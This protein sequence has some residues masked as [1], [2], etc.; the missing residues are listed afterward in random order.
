MTGQIARMRF[1]LDALQQ[2]CGQPDRPLS[3]CPTCRA[4][5][6]GARWYQEDDTVKVDTIPPEAQRL[7]AFIVLDGTNLEWIARCPDCGRLYWM[8]DEYEYS[9]NS[10]STTDRTVTRVDNAEALL[11]R[12]KGIRQYK[13]IVRDGNVWRAQKKGVWAA[14]RRDS[15]ADVL[16]RFATTEP[17]PLP[18][19]AEPPRAATV[20]IG[21]STIPDVLYDLANV[22]P[23]FEGV[24]LESQLQT[25]DGFLDIL[26]PT[27][28]AGICAL[29]RTAAQA[30]TISATRARLNAAA[31]AVERGDRAALP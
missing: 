25:Y 10:P 18:S 23:T 4:I 22:L 1:T 5:P 12:M 24:D 13:D 29:F 2:I 3:D 30:T 9:S 14:D 28:R 19:P 26:A 21:D 8:T 7:V 6:D 17:Q 27:V 11:R 31:D 16:K 15:V 20:T